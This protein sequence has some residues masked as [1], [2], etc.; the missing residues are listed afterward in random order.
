[1]AAVRAKAS[2]VRINPG[3]SI[4]AVVSF[5]VPDGTTGTDTVELHNSA[6]SPV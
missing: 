1:M 2:N 6:L 5:G 4:T 3:S